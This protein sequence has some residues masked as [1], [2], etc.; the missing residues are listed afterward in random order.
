MFIVGCGDVVVCDATFVVVGNIVVDAFDGTTADDIVTP[1][2][3]KAVVDPAAV[4]VPLIKL[5][6]IDLSSS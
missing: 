6:E 3:V 4:V 2:V 1:N 5:I